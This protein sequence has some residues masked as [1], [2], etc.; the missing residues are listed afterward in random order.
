M[1]VNS[2]VKPIMFHGENGETLEVQR[3]NMG[4]PYRDGV[5]FGFDDEFNFVSIF[6]NVSEI[7]KLKKFLNEYLVE[8]K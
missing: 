3:D 8:G 1:K 7:R 4:E 2:Q 5:H 6:L